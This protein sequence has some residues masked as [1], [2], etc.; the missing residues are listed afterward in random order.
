MESGW[1]FFLQAHDCLQGTARPA[2]YVV[3]RNDLTDQ[4]LGAQELEKIVSSNTGS[5]HSP[6]TENEHG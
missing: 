2:H 4:G 5:N 3:L 6:S 1:D